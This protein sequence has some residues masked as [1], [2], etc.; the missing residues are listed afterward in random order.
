M[1]FK[2]VEKKTFKDHTNSSHVLHRMFPVNVILTVE[3]IEMRWEQWVMLLLECTHPLTVLTY[4]LNSST[5]FTHLLT[6]LIYIYFIHLRT[7]RIYLL[8]SPIY[9]LTVLTYLLYSPTY[10][11]H[12][13]TVLILLSASTFST[14]YWFC[15]T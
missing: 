12:L 9:I 2:Y 15:W 10:C 8:Y 1:H 13:L 7:V 14:S 11:I 6:L 3:L 5:Y 4:L